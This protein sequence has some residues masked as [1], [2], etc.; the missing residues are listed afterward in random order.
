M[1][2]VT[3]CKGA[4]SFGQLVD[5]GKSPAVA[6][7]WLG[8]IIEEEIRATRLHHHEVS[9]LS[10]IVMPDHFH[11]LVFVRERI[12]CHFGRILNGLKG[13]ITKRA[14]LVASNLA[15]TVFG[16]G[17]HD[18]IIDSAGQ[19]ETLS[20][21]IADNPRRL[22]IKRRHPDL[23][24]R[25]NHL[26]IGDLQF[27]AYG[28]IFLLRNCDKQVVIVHRRYT[29]AE[30]QSLERQWLRCAENGGVLVS[31]FISPA[32]KRIRD[33]ALAV[34]GSLIILRAEGFP[35]RF[36][37]GGSEFELCD[38][39][40]LL[41]LAPWPYSSRKNTITRSQALSLNAMAEQIAAISSEPVT[42][43]QD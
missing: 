42:L 29:P 38:S 26:R 43:V 27:A 13:A 23:F 33:Q 37:P 19:L 8:F 36:K 10:Q 20:R 1:V 16:E 7:S 6:L 31:P 12:D 34:G 28:N 40:R 18:R 4:P 25:Y 24:R 3:A 15:L 21:Y 30:L 2:T 14:R 17:F 11:M 39:G 41:L 35:E 22:A 32:E 5:D 9:V